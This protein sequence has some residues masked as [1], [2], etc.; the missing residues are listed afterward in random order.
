M[1]VYLALLIMTMLGA[2][3]AFCLKRAVGEAKRTW[4]LLCNRFFLIGG[5]LY[6]ISAVLNIY[7][8]KFLP[9]SVVLPFT[10]ITYIWTLFLAKEFL[11]EKIGRSKKAGMAMIIVGVILIA[12]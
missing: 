10:A 1:V 9:Y 2:V 12:C 3:A 4:M 8:L 5:I 6:F 7:A 11:Q